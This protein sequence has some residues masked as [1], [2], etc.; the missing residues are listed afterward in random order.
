MI[1]IPDDVPKR[2][3]KPAY[4]YSFIKTVTSKESVLQLS[5]QIPCNGKSMSEFEV[6]FSSIFG[7][8]VPVDD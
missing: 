1:I 6:I 4:A 3:A 7:V 2:R 8:S 5:E